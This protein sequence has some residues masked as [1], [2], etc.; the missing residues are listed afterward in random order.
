MT[1][2]R[3]ESDAHALF[4]GALIGLAW[5]HRLPIELDIDDAG[6]YLP[7]WTLALPGLPPGVTLTIVIPP[8]PADL[9]I[10]EWIEQAPR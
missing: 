4:A 6:N 7:S 8:P 9:D 1:E 2:R 3:Y 10:A 5:R